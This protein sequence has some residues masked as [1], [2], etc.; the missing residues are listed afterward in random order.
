MFTS[1]N[2]SDSVESPE[3]VAKPTV[4]KS[5]LPVST[6]GGSGLFDDEDDEDDFFSGNGVK[7]S[8]PGKS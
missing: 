3:N 8:E 4:S 2:D 7:K 6:S 5:S 1:A